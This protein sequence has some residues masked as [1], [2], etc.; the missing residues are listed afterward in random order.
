[1]TRNRRWTVLGV[2]TGLYLVGLGMLGGMVSERLR[3]DAARTRIVSQLEE[4]TRRAHTHA[5]ARELELR[6]AAEPAASPATDTE[7]RPSVWRGYLEMVD[8]ALARRDVT[9]A[10][11][12][13]REAHAAALRTR[14]WRPLVETGDALMRIAH[15]D[16][17]QPGYVAQ[18]RQNYLAALT[19]ARADRSADGVLR[20]AEAF[21]ALGDHRVAED[22]LV[23]AERLGASPDHEV[24]VHL[25]ALPRAVDARGTPRFEP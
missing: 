24:I 17:R 13:W 21:S 12:A 3:F 18:A 20:V 6:P 4:A 14:T 11:R 1:M 15:V 23:I 5:M 7:R 8:A 16:G 2:L 10:I 9:T 22:C 25:R 19:R